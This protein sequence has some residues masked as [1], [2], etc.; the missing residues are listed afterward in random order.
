MIKASFKVYEDMNE[1]QDRVQTHNE[2]NKLW[3][4]TVCCVKNLRCCH[5]EQDVQIRAILTFC[6]DQNETSISNYEKMFKIDPSQMDQS[7]FYNSEPI[8]PSSI[9]Q[10]R[11]KLMLVVKIN[12]PKNRRH[13]NNEFLVVDYVFDPISLKNVRI[14]TPYVIKFRQTEV[15]QMY[16]LEF[17][18][19]INSNAEEHVFNKH[20]AN[21][22][23]CDTRSNTP[24]CGKIT[25]NGKDVPYSQ[26][27][28]C[29]C[30]PQKNYERQPEST[31]Y[32][33]E[34]IVTYSNPVFL[35]NGNECPRYLKAKELNEDND[36]PSESWYQYVNPNVKK[37]VRSE[38]RVYL[39]PR[40]SSKKRESLQD[41][42][43]FYKFGYSKPKLKRQVEVSSKQQRGWQNCADS[44]TPEDANP[45]SYHDSAHCLKFSNVW[46]S[47]YRL[48]K[49]QLEHSILIQVFE[50]HED[51][52]GRVIWKDL[53]K[54]KMNRVGTISNT[55]E[56]D[57]QIVIKYSSRLRY[58]D[59]TA[60]AINY[61]SALLLVPDGVKK[62]DY[63]W[64][65]EVRNGP[66]EYLIVH[67][68][69]I[70]SNGARCNVGG[71]GFEAFFKQPNRCSRPRGTCLANQPYKL[72]LHDHQAE[73]AGKKGCFFLKNYG[74]FP[75]N[76]IR[77]DPKTKEQYL[78][79]DFSNIE[80]VTINMEIR[81]D[82]NA[83]LNT[84]GPAKI[85]EVYID[86]T[87]SFKT[88]II[89]KVT[90][91]GLVSGFFLT[92][93]QNCPLEIP[94][95][96]SNIESDSTLI[97]PQHQHTFHLEIQAVLPLNKFHCTVEALNHNRELV[98]MRR[99]LIQSFDRCICTWHCLCA[100]FGYKEGL[101]CIPMSLQHYHAAGFRGSLPITIVE[102]NYTFLDEIMTF[103]MYLII[104]FVIALLLLGL[105]KG[106]LGAIFNLRQIG[107]FG[108]DKILEL[109]QPILQYYEI[110]LSRFE[111]IYNYEGW[112]IHPKTGEPVRCIKRSTELC[113]NILFFFIYPICLC[114][115]TW[116]RL[117]KQIIYL[118][119]NNSDDDSSKSNCSCGYYCNKICDHT[120]N[121]SSTQSCSC[122]TI[123]RPL[124][125]IVSKSNTNTNIK[126]SSK[127][128]KRINDDNI[129]IKFVHKKP[130]SEENILK[131][132]SNN[133]LGLKTPDVIEGNPQST[134]YTV[135]SVP[136][137]SEDSLI[138]EKNVTQK[139]QEVKEEKKEEEEEEETSISL[140]VFVR[141]LIDDTNVL[142]ADA[143]TYQSDEHE[144]ERF[145][146]Q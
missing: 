118:Y 63:R 8:S 130:T 23:G 5:K 33:T 45:E 74:T 98:A 114:L 26:G 48:N 133:D 16:K 110:E 134:S 93:L 60:F 14:L 47:V 52:S 84:F 24:T 4:N 3:T 108:L 104:Y 67:N 20:S 9:K 120:D 40:L 92:R 41:L 73:N 66:S 113:I 132:Q 68:N 95:S 119:K 124:Q 2:L 19:V 35:L 72:W 126:A 32:Y 141:S 90:N 1:T 142:S 79:I 58:T 146:E 76:P 111:V 42:I 139:K 96:F 50:R 22:T 99:I 100:C 61:K 62:E 125:K 137:L 88:T 131:I 89:I 11:K 80:P 34:D 138:K 71:V 64:H 54:G 82:F 143:W 44:Y 77:R 13:I 85:T 106:I 49:P 102:V 18:H 145:N 46:Y 116:Q 37:I 25:Y 65:P 83:L 53:T 86:S 51:T 38:N 10:C 36:F 127:H 129:Q 87:Y 31:D 128:E 21:Y 29:S 105:V 27:F 17:L 6:K 91:S 117:R 135:V 81:A 122:K 39:N 12:T 97:P 75:D 112:P 107:M 15:S 115:F 144:D 94:A 69:Q 101:K 109:P 57:D 7:S 78:V 56:D 136:K 43:N 55:Y 30:D 70:R 121:T 59:H 140:E 123:W 103:V 28:C